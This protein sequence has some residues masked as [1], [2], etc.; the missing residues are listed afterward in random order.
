MTTTNQYPNLNIYLCVYK[1]QML[2]VYSI[3]FKQNNKNLLYHDV[4][5][6][7]KFIPKRFKRDVNS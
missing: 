4:K 5:L 7:L 6:L 1:K 3:F 2:Y